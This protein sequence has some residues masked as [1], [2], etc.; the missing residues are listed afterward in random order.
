M[1]VSAR[2]LLSGEQGGGREDKAR[3]VYGI[4]NILHAAVIL[5][6]N[7][8]MQQYLVRTMHMYGTSGK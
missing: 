1:L 5:R 7:S 4:S 3:G 6:R 2:L 8:P